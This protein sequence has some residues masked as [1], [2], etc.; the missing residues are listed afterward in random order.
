M[1]IITKETINQFVAA[2]NPRAITQTGYW[3]DI[4]KANQK[5]SFIIYTTKQQDITA[6]VLL[7]KQLLPFGKN[8]LYAPYGPVIKKDLTP[9]QILPVI[10]DLILEINKF[11]NLQN[12]VFIRF[13]PFYQDCHTIFSAL[14][15]SGFQSTNE[16]TQPK[17]TSILN[18]RQTEDQLFRSFHQ[19][20]RYNIRLAHKKNVKVVKSTDISEIKYFYKLLLNTC[21]RDKF[22][23]HPQKHY[24]NILQILGPK[25]IAYVYHAQYNQKII[26][27]IIVTFF[28][29]VAS[30][31]HGASSN[32]YR[33]LMPNYALQWQAIRDAINKD[34]HFY[35]FGGIAPPNAPANHPWH[36][37]TRFKQ[38]FNGIDVSTMGHLEK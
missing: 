1:A 25:D 29:H 35:D 8:Y 6:S 33:N 24:Q 16:F 32:T 26:A 20:T 13:E 36:G 31:L 7:I 17:D 14:Q 2:N 27:S 15:S 5:K 19:K 28:G 38:G 34:C 10:N 21:D 12:T 11:I 18:L 37:I 30:Y 3:L 22:R 9:D 4:E 23:P